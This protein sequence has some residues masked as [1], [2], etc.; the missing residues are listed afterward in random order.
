MAAFMDSFDALSSFQQAL[1]AYRTSS[2][3]EASVSG[4]GGYPPVNVFRKGDDF[5][6]IAELPGVKK[7]DLEVQVKGRTIR[8]AGTKTVGYPEKAALHRRERLAGRFDRAVT[9]P[10]EINADRVKAEDRDG[11]LAL[12]LPRDESEKPKSIK[13]A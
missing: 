12:F 4:G 1:D 5:I 9:M 2:W 7:S 10:V 8:L 3:L 13:V 6:I 11:V